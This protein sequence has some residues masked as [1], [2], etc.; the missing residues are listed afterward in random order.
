VEVE[1]YYF[2]EDQINNNQSLDFWIEPRI[3]IVSIRVPPEVYDS[4]T[5]EIEKRGIDYKIIIDDLQPLVEEQMEDILARGPIV[6][7]VGNADAFA[8]N[9]Y[10]TVD[11]IHAWMRTLPT[12]YPALNFRIFSV[13]NSHNGRQLLT[14][15]LSSKNSRAEKSVWFDGGIHAREW[16]SPATVC[17]MLFTLCENYTNGV[18]EVVDLVD[19]LD[20][21][22]L[23]VFNPDGYAYTMSNDRM[24]RKT[25]RPNPGSTCVGTDPNR[26]WN[27]HWSEQGVS[28]NP[29]AETYCG[30]NADSEI[31]VRQV[32]N[33]LVQLQRNP[34]HP[35]VGY[36]NFHAYS[37]LWLSPYGWRSQ[38]TPDNTAL[39]TLARTATIALY[40]WYGTSF[41]YG[42]IYTT[43][44]PASGSSCDFTYDNG[45]KF[46]YAPELR[47]AG[48]S[49]GFLLPAIQIIPSGLETFEALKVW[50]RT[51]INSG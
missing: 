48:A 6:E 37:Q 35:L 49:P 17:Y 22:V 26:N 33:H 29:C 24:W 2:L 7:G 19:S 36:I 46:S 31:E 45:I 20:I 5:E 9:Q 34:T 12:R 40:E 18:Q 50:L 3:G 23:P 16:I 1:D 10:N 44:Y 27:N 51:C 13:G 8:I 11:D 39:Q 4:F 28:F 32:S 43:I 21:Y 30:P 47:P 41:T 38:P 15:H 25:R 14:V 42:P